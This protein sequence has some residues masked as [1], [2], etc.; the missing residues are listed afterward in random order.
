MQNGGVHYRTWCKHE[1][2]TV[3]I[4]DTSGTPLRQ[5]SMEPE[6]AGYFSAFDEAGAAGDLYQYRFGESAGWPDPSSRWQPAG[7]HGPSM[8]IDPSP[9][10]WTDSTWTAPPFSELIIYEVHV[11]TFTPAGTFRAAIERFDHLVTLGVNA[12]ELMP[13]ADFPGNRNWGYDGVMLYAPARA[14]G[15]PDDLRAL[16]DA[17]HARGLAVI[18]DV[19][20]NHLGPD[21]NY[22]S[23]YHGDYENSRQTTPWGAALNYAAAPV[24]AFFVENPPYWRRE[25]HID[26][27]RFDATHEIADP[28]M[29]HILADL[30]DIVHSLGGFAMAE[31]ERNEPRLLQPVAQGGSGF[32]GVW[33]D[34]FHHVLR[35][36]LTGDNEGYFA[37]YK[38]TPEEMVET[39]AHGWLFRGQVQPTTGQPRGGD[40]SGLAPPQFVYC[41]SNHDQVGNRALG[42][43]IGQV[44]S[45][46]AY[47]AA[48]AFL[49]L[50]PQT[51]LLF[52]GQEWCAFTPFQ[53]FTDHNANLGRLV[54]EGRRHEFRNF[55]AF[56]DPAMRE[57]IPDPQAP[58]TFANSRLRWEELE[59]PA[60]EGVLRLY[61][62]FLRLR[63]T[64]PAFRDRSQDRWGALVLEDGI[65]ALRYGRAHEPGC[66]VLCDLR[67][68]HPLPDLDQTPLRLEGGQRWQPLL[69]SEERRF[70]GEEAPGFAAPTTRIFETT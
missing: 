46:A 64:H 21:G 48:S 33:A 50:V 56:R 20:Y 62:E 41:I 67:G 6:G 19:V 69:S 15:H 25:F 10:P 11:G 30:T 34:D 44:V 68:G 28:S 9:F 16:V 2:A 60:H 55:A 70:G 53:F 57:T 8:V 4:V 39:L 38:G 35:V 36:M 27:F 63:R 3:C 29:P 58:Q 18:L 66:L 43:R 47:R 61:Q 1:R 14:Y 22:T 45:P 52:M 49:C 13:V 32:D 7:V 5:V 51:P 23:V 26:G 59:Q 24:R 54:T 37:N 31:D 12:I 65:F 42:E 17:A 40:P